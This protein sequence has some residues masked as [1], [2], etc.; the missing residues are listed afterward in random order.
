MRTH[1][2]LDVWKEA[3]EFV[4]EVYKITAH[5]PKKRSMA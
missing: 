2:D 5:I 3:V 1:K 4:E